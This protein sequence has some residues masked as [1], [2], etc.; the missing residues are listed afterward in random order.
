MVQQAGSSY[1][2]LQVPRLHLWIEASLARMGTPSMGTDYVALEEYYIKNK[3]LQRLIIKPTRSEAMQ[4]GTVP[5]GES[6]GW[7]DKQFRSCCQ[8]SVVVSAMVLSDWSNLRYCRIILAAAQRAQ[9]W[10]SST[11]K[12]L[13]CSDDIEKWIVAQCTGAF[14]EHVTS[15]VFACESPALLQ[16]AQFMVS[17]STCRH[18]DDGEVMCEDEFADTL[19]QICSS[20]AAHRLRRMLWLVWGWP[21]SMSAVLEESY[22]D[23]TMKRFETDLRVWTALQSSKNQVKEYRDSSNGTPS[24]SLAAAS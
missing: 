21:W 7:D 22:A 5:T 23:E 17:A 9:E 19:G 6:I 13:R 14:M 2:T 18:C 8:N 1:H 3:S 20:L 16:E 11:N 15:I 12:A 24:R 4:D 10:H